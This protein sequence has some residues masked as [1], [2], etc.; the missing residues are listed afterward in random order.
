MKINSSSSL[1]FEQ[2]IITLLNER[3]LRDARDRIIHLEPSDIAELIRQVEENRQ[4]LIFRILPRELATLVFEYLEFDTQLDLLSS[5]GGRRISLILNQM[6]PD[7]RT[8]LL[9]RLPNYSVSNFLRMLTPEERKVAQSLLNYP[10][11]SIGRIMTPDFIAVRSE[12]TVQQVLDFIRK[13]GNDSETLN[14]IYA[15]DSTQKLIDDI[16]I[17]EFLLHPLNT[18][19]SELCNQTVISLNVMD[20]QEHAVEIFKKYDR[21]VLPVVDESNTLLGIVTVDDVLDIAEQKDTEDIQ[22]IGGMHALDDP[23]FNTSLFSLVKKRASWLVIL[24][25]GEMLT[26]SAMTAFQSEISRAVVLALFIPLI[27]SSGGNSGSQAATLIIRALTIGEITLRDWLKVMR[28]EILSGL[29]L[30]SILGLIGF[31]RVTLWS[32]F[33]DIYGEHYML[34]AA[35]VGIS[36]VGVVLWGCIAGSMLPFLLKKLGADPATSSAPFVATLVDVTG[37]IIYFCLAS[38]ILGQT[39]LK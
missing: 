35:V 13:Y 8:A 39:L 34:I 33:S 28:R 18:K 37:L 25:I 26:T 21:A 24:L 3:K 38:L 36:L 17:R 2:E 11:G 10:S 27:I 5:I 9:E 14:V 1:G 12:W 7:D 4:A 20:D 32:Q 15:V 23:Y 30:G 31:F 22:K 19:V 6:S 16:K 29:M